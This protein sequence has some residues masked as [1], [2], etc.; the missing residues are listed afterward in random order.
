VL[1]DEFS[2]PG[3]YQTVSAPAIAVPDVENR[4]QPLVIVVRQR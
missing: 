2:L 1:P 4:A 3:R